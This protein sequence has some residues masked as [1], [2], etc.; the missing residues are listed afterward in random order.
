MRKV[1]YILSRKGRMAKGSIM[2]MTTVANTPI[3]QYSYANIEGR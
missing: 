1:S 2:H 3:A